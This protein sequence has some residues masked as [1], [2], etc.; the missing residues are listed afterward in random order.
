MGL[1]HD[2]FNCST[3]SAGGVVCGAAESQGRRRPVRLLGIP[4]TEYAHCACA[5]LAK[6]GREMIGRRWRGL[7]PLDRCCLGPREI[8][9]TYPTKEGLEQNWES[10]CSVVDNR[11][12]LIR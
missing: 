10:D 5:A 7:G 6:M 11:K 2:G 1:I 4:I 9:A 12:S 8:L 3:K